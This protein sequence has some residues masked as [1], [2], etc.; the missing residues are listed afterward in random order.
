[1]VTIKIVTL[2]TILT[3]ASASTDLFSLYGPW[4]AV[5]VF[6]MTDEKSIKGNKCA[7]LK[8]KQS[9]L[10]CPCGNLSLTVLNLK[11]TPGTLDKSYT[12]VDDDMAAFAVNSFEE[13]KEVG[14]AV[15]ENT[16]C[17]CQLPKS[18]FQTLSDNYFI[19]YFLPI[20]KYYPMGYLFAR[21]L[22]TYA[23][24]KT[25][26]NSL[27]GVGNGKLLCYKQ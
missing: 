5:K 13:A 8:I 25:F 4:I 26:S 14:K 23:E 12:V 16:E 3:L 7:K 18:A 11:L 6:G 15:L 22:P 20:K 2:L 27:V 10:D 1:M 24:L 21:T 9:S 19:L 17:R